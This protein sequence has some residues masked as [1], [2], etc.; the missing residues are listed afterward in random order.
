[1][2]RRGFQAAAAVALAAAGAVAAGQ[3]TTPRTA[4]FHLTGL[5]VLGVKV[6]DSK[7]MDIVMIDATAASVAHQHLPRIC[8]KAA[9]VVVADSAPSDGTDTAAGCV[10]W[11]LEGYDATVSGATDVGITNGTG[12]A[13]IPQLSKMAK[14]GLDTKLLGP[15]PGP[16]V[17]ARVH[18][19]GGTLSSEFP[20]SG[21]GDF[22][23]A[24]FKFD[25]DP[26][27]GS[28]ESRLA[29]SMLTQS[30]PGDLTITLTALPGKTKPAKTIKLRSA[31][32]ASPL[33]VR[34]T[35]NTAIVVCTNDKQVRE[36]DHFKAYYKILAAPP[37]AHQGIPKEK[38]HVLACPGSLNEYIRCPP[39]EG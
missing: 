5:E 16:Y 9:D 35:N 14:S 1:M 18:L 8:A 19:A 37:A 33:D 22:T 23:K 27:G 36:L 39:P 31:S 11:S 38:T 4:R 30:L 7:K 17:A 26:D 6:N 34:I 15:E 28:Y 13:D 29:D 25:P 20:S 21:V 32:P 2:D 12:A 10:Y 3:Q 24:V